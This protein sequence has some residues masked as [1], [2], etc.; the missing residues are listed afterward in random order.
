MVILQSYTSISKSVLQAYNQGN[1][2]IGAVQHHRNTAQQ[3]TG[4]QHT[5]TWLNTSMGLQI[6]VALHL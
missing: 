2:L 5:H 6:W 1:T 3:L 4:L